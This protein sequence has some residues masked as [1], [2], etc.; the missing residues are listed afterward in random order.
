MAYENYYQQATASALSAS[1]LG[2][3][4]LASRGALGLVDT[5][6]PSYPPPGYPPSYLGSSLPA[7]PTT[8]GPHGQSHLNP[9][10]PP[11]GH[12]DVS[13]SEA[14]AS[15]S[16]LNFLP[17][18]IGDAS[19]LGLSKDLFA[20]HHHSLPPSSVATTL[21][22]LGGGSSIFGGNSNV[23]A[24]MGSGNVDLLAA[25]AAAAATASSSAPGAHGGG[26][27]MQQGAA[28]GMN[29][30]GASGILGGGPNILGGSHHGV[31]LTPP[32]HPAAS[33]L[34]SSLCSVLPHTPT[35]LTPPTNTPTREDVIRVA[36]SAPSNQGALHPMPPSSSS[37]SGSLGISRN[38]GIHQRPPDPVW[39]PY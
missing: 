32:M 34:Y 19:G 21:S 6:W 13:I 37:S 11:G 20:P 27:S 33:L 10:L 2:F 28:H 14:V 22:M 1:G 17:D 4:S 30:G 3:D 23:L 39:R 18:Q 26:S 38:S 15:S 29:G 36:G 9:A 8:H 7:C 12:R 31:Y 16:H 5:G 25:A 35:T 24:G